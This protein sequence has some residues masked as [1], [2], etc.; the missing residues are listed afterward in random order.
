MALVVS[1]CAGAVSTS[2]TSVTDTG[3]TLN[4]IVFSP[5]DGTD[6]YWFSY[7]KNT[8]YGSE[9]TH[10]T[11]TIS[12]RNNHPVS[13]PVSGLASGTPY[14]YKLCAE[15]S[16]LTVVCGG[17]ETFTT[18]GTAPP[19]SITA[20]PA[21][22]PNFAPAVSD[23]VTRC[24]TAPVAMTVA[25]PPGTSVAI[26]GQPS[27]S[28]D[29][30]QN[31]Q[32]SP[33]QAFAIS[34][35]TGG[36]TKTFN[37]RCLPANFPGWTYTRNGTPSAPFYITTPQGSKTP[38]GQSAPQYVA[39]FDDN[40]VPVWWDQAPGSDAKL[41]SDGTLGWW[42]ATAG[43]GSTPGFET[44]HLDGSLVHTW[45]TVG[46]ATDVHDFQ[47][48]ANGDALLLSYPPRPGTIDLSPYGGPSQNATILE[49]EIQEVAPDGSLVWSWN[50]NGHIDPSETGQRWWS[51]Y[52]LPCRR[53]FPMGVKLRLR[54]RELRS[55]NRQHDHR[56]FPPS[57][58][59][60]RD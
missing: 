30:T 8:S 21:L 49:P 37:V 22:Y 47:Q 45:R 56:L 4:G 36:Q 41:L 55:G 28:G 58:C 13:E 51:P 54:P 20:A 59:R 29:F 2:A 23:Y 15:D 19:L 43:G 60:L 27:Q 46:S 50:A 6:S 24:G 40:G 57:R 31:V 16:S 9:T 25:A 11:I 10:R 18:T 33:G 12:D 35:T 17:D 7:G 32:L 42:T 26:D 3:A 34:T 48:L 39:I 38:D 52:F 44:H 53:L 1:G 14:H 5:S